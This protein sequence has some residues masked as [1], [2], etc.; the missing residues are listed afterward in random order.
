LIFDEVI[1]HAKLAFRIA[2]AANWRQCVSAEH[3]GHLPEL[4][5]EEIGACYQDGVISCLI[6]TSVLANIPNVTLVTSS[7]AYNLY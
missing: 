1:G 3:P 5:I 6:E 2:A 7:T 4:A